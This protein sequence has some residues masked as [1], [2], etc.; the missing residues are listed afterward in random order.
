MKIILIIVVF[1]C[2]VFIGLKISQYYKKRKKFFN[3]LC[4]YCDNLKISIS[5]SQEKLNNI[6]QKF[7]KEQQDE[8]AKL[9]KDFEFFIQN[10]I[11]E[12]EFRNCKELYF[13]NKDEKEDIM[14]FF[15][16]LGN[17]AK[18]EEIEKIEIST[19]KFQNYYK[20]VSDDYKKFSSLYLK[21]F[22]VIGLAVVIIFI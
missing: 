21:L 4:S 9:L 13:L 2:C 10:K 7:I 6:T 16:S 3:S 22:I 17:M 19:L 8:F 1:I 18:D 20:K 15:C 11:S 12:N 5:Y 14:C